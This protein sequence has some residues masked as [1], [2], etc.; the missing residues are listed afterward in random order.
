MQIPNSLLFEGIS[1]EDVESMMECLLVKRCSYKK[2][3]FI[4]HSG[5]CVDQIGMVVKGKVHIIKEDFWGNRM[6]LGEAVP[7]ELFG[8]VYVCA[9]AEQL[10][11]SVAAKM[12]TE[13]MFLDL[14][15]VLTV[16]SNGCKFHSK[17][18]QNL[19]FSIAAR[20]LAM[21]R[22]IEHM[23]KKSLRGKILS[24]LSSEAIRTGKREFQISYNRQQLAEY[25]SVDRSA[26]SAEL[27]R[28]QKDGILE[29]QK[30]RFRLYEE[31]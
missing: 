29:F 17:M 8:E 23:S 25:L 11:V 9:K 6:I 5:D 1:Q 30:N 13:V 16:C 28:M 19:L 22:K 12:D 26:L 18:I 20:T 15:K 14:Q 4:F 24:Y 21:T 2:D 31:L 7:G 3:E 27:G 10:E